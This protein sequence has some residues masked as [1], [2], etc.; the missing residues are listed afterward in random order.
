MHI[1]FRVFVSQTL[2]TAT[3]KRLNYVYLSKFF[4]NLRRIQHA[5]S[6]CLETCFRLQLMTISS[7]S[8]SA[9]FSF[10]PLKQLQAFAA[11]CPKFSHA[12]ITRNLKKL[13]GVQIWKRFGSET[14]RISPRFPKGRESHEK[15][16]STSKHRT[17]FRSLF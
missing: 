4:Y 13:H 7:L 5:W 15:K 16:S 3:Y 2:A 8:F 17:L 12:Q 6:C 1:L 10:F 9:I 11:L 14:P